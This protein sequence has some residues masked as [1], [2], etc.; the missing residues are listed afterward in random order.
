MDKEQ[1]LTMKDKCL[2]P[3]SCKNSAFSETHISWIVLTDQYA[4]KVKRPVQLPFLDFSTLENRRF[5]CNQ[6]IKLNRRL[7]PDMYLGIVPITQ[8]LSTGKSDHHSEEDIIDYAVQMKRMDNNKE[9]H[10]M[11]AAN[12]VTEK[13]LEKLAGKIAQ[14]HKNTQVVKNAFNTAGMINEFAAI[15]DVLDEDTE[16]QL[17]P[18]ESKKIVSQCIEKSKNY[19]NDNRSFLNDRILNDFQRDCHGDLN[20][21]NI[22]LYDDPVIFDC[23]EF[24]DDF[25]YIDVLNEIAF[26]CVDLDFSGNKQL[27]NSFVRNYM[28]AFELKEKD[29]PEPLFNFYKCYR[30]NV[31]AKVTL[32]SLKEHPKEEKKQEDVKKYIQL[33]QNYAKMF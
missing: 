32:I 5:Y 3:D 24:N 16:N 21:T 19:L 30:A 8:S 22:F 7:A 33:M 28:K 18:A 9:M 11:L 27:S 13:H 6:E 12:K 4:F 2:F 31:R 29:M 10:K 25:R 1:I 15:N 26:L 14:F 23:I 17:I 20:A